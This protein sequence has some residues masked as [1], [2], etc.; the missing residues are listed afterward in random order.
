MDALQNLHT[1][2]TFCDGKDAPEQLIETALSLGLQSIGF[3]GHSYMPFAPDHSMSQQG[4]ADYRNRI[5]ALKEQYRGKIDVFCGLEEELYSPEDNRAYDYRIGSTHYFYIDGKYVGFD[6]SASIVQG[7]IN[8]YFGGDGMAYAKAYYEQIINL[9]KRGKFD[10]LGHF[11]LITKHCQTQNFFD[12]TSP[13]YLAY[14]YDA[15]DALAGKIPLFEVNTGAI[16]R[17]YRTTPYPTLP[18]LKQFKQ[19][20]F[21]AVIG[22]DCH[23]K[24]QLTCSFEQAAALLREAGF[25]ERYI[26]TKNAFTA[27][28]LTEDKK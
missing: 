17:G 26:L 15:I 25:T 22:S 20:G 8:E 19:K 23:D 5:F 7:V 14:A 27:V 9:P 28:P 13:K 10:I 3:S 4:T 11:D 6:R 18:L 12:V 1:H 2:T 21:G 24:T 16:A